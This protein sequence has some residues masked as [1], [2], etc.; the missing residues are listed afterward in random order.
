M[1]SYGR[2]GKIVII[3]WQE[4]YPNGAFRL[5]Y[6][7]VRV[8]NEKK[9]EVYNGIVPIWN[10]CLYG[11]GQLCLLDLEL[12]SGTY[13]VEPLDL[14]EGFVY[15]REYKIS[16]QQPIL[17]LRLSSNLLESD[18]DFDLIAEGHGN[19]QVVPMVRRSCR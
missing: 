3:C 15:Q 9:E 8:T 14:P 6:P 11:S 17:D 18:A 7:S 1:I 12:P 10:G 16:P 4:P 19:G 13:T 2:C 5:H